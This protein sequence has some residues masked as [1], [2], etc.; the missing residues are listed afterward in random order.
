MNMPFSESEMDV[1][2]FD[3]DSSTTTLEFDALASPEA[4]TVVHSGPCCEK[5]GTPYKSD[6]TTVCRRC[7]WYP[8]LQQHIDVDHEWEV[9][10]DEDDQPPLREAPESHLQVWLA[11]MPRWGW[12]LLATVAAVVVESVV[13]RLATTDGSRLRTSWSLT[14]IM[15]GVLAFAG[16]HVF[17]FIAAAA[18]D[19][20]FG[21]QDILLKP[22]KLWMKAL[23]DLPERQWVV[24]AA[25][26][27]LTAV[28]MSIVVIGGIPYDRLW[29]WGIEKR[30]DP[31]LLGAVMS[32]MQEVNRG[33]GA[34]NLEDA[35]GDLA[36]KA[37]LEEGKH[38]P[39]PPPKP[40]KKID[41]V[42]IGYRTDT[43]GRLQSLILAT[44]LRDRLVYACSIMPNMPSD[45]IADL[46][47]K[48]EAIASH[49]P[50]LNVQINAH[51]VE[52]KYTCRISFEEQERSGR[53][54]K[55]Q[56]DEM[57]GTLGVQP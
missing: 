25:A 1:L 39:A 5:C 16:S 42:I 29:D 21:V 11:M 44:A 47:T 50:Y 54:T 40:R 35:V 36:G 56:W 52:P 20:D 30:S 2:N 53:L 51:W 43:E 18:E 9:Y 32:R 57:L 28:V 3:R 26:A 55:P 48:L 49:Q 14:Q 24:D 23:R 6:L 10:G 17:N 46:L 22:V 19:S 34:D 31:N 7:G 13:V 33:R 8:L 27:G 38:A 37:K 4:P 15:V 41:C 45:E 12:I